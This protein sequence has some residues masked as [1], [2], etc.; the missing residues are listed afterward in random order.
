MPETITKYKPAAAAT[1]TKAKAA[2]AKPAAKAATKVS[3]KPLFY[4]SLLGECLSGKRGTV[5]QRFY[6]NATK[7][8]LSIKTVFPRARLA[9]Q[10]LLNPEDAVS[11]LSK[12]EKTSI[13]A[14]DRTGQRLF[15]QMMLES[16]SASK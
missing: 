10:P 2:K 8:H 13:P 5:L 14:G 3:A 6:V 4:A 1:T 9:N 16:A 11:F 12:H 15:D 7:Y